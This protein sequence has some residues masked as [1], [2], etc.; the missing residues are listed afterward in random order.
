MAIDNPYL[1]SLVRVLQS[2]SLILW[3]TVLRRGAGEAQAM[4]QSVPNLKKPADNRASLA[5]DRPGGEV[6]LTTVIALDLYYTT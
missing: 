3:E 2:I 6:M 4:V 1:S 5:L